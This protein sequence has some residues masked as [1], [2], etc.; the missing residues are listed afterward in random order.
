MINFKTDNFEGPLGLLLK[1]I[2]KE[3]M[4]ITKVSMAKIADQYVEYIKISDKINPDDMADFLVVA[5]KLLLI[6]SRALLPFLHIDEEEDIDE[7]EAQLKMYKE[8]IEATARIEKIIGKRKFMFGRSFNRKAVMESAEIFTPPKIKKEEVRDIFSEIIER[9]KPI[10]EKLKEEKLDYK[11]SIEDKIMSIQKLLLNKIKFSFS[12]VI[13]NANSKTEVI[14][15]FL[16]ML[17]LAKQKELV[18]SQKSL[19]E[20]IVIKNYNN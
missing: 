2:E 4:D 1:I 14:V 5:A 17:E 15:S 8:F 3:E 6:K 18:I 9:I 7:L 12:K 11:L 10:E 20:D 16:A 13:K 19:F